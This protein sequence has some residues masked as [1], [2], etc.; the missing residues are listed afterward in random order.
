M[1]AL[2]DKFCDLFPNISFDIEYGKIK[3]KLSMETISSG[4]REIK[5]MLTTAKSELSKVKKCHKQGK[6]AVEEVFDCEWRVHELELELLKFNDSTSSIDE[7]PD[8]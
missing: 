1:N 2:I 4:E 3:S 7:D 8:Y 5:K 6:C